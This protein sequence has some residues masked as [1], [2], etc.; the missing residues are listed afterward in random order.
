LRLLGETAYDAAYFL[1]QLGGA[2][3]GYWNPELDGNGYLSDAFYGA[4]N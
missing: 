2:F 1:D 4:A 3:A